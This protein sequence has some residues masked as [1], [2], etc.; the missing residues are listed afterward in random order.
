M[1]RKHKLLH[2]IKSNKS[3]ERQE[4]RKKLKPRKSG[5]L[6]KHATLF[7]HGFHKIGGQLPNIKTTKGILDRKASKPEYSGTIVSTNP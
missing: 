4:K 2:L 1:E 6:P 5:K 3:T 7:Q